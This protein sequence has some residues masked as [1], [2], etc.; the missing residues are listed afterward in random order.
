M[1]RKLNSLFIIAAIALLTSCTP[2]RS[3]HNLAYGPGANQT[4]DFYEPRVDV[5]GSPRPALL[6]IHGGGYVSGD[7]SW[8]EKVAEKFCPWGYVVV[9][10][11]YTLAPEGTW[12]M[13]LDEAQIAL[14]HMRSS[15][16]MDIK[17]PIAG[18]GVSAGAHL[19]AALHLMGDLPIAVGASGPWDFIHCS[20]PQLDEPLRLLLGLAPGAPIPPGLRAMMSPVTWVKPSADMLLIHAKHDPLIPFQNAIN[21]EAALRAVG[22]KVVLLPIDSDSHSA[23]WND[24]I[25]TTL[26]WLRDKQ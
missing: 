22:A 26:R 5:A 25:W 4:Y 8:A 9:G 12:P 15:P 24:A 20:T 21:F 1:I 11:N 23:A 2:Y 14:N 13:Q 18:F 17:E 16:W 10:I 3:T 7:K 19:A 6:V